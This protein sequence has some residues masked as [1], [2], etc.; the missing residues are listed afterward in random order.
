MRAYL[1]DN[2]DTQKIMVGIE[3]EKNSSIGSILM[4]EKR[5]SYLNATCVELT[6]TSFLQTGNTVSHK[7]LRADNIPTVI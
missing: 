6:K 7:M 1:R 2:M 5:C 3:I 4:K